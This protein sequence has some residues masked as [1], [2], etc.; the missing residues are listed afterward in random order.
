[1]EQPARRL[2]S[3]AG[4]KQKILVLCH[5]N[6]DPDAISSAFALKSLFS[7][8]LKRKAVIGFGGIVGRAENRELI[9]RLKI[10]MVQAQEIDFRRFSFICLVDS[11]PGI[12]NNSLPHGLLPNVVIDHHPLL[13]GTKKCEFYDVRPDYGSTATILTEY[14]RELGLRVE[15]RLATALFYGLKTDTNNLL[16]STNKADMDTF[17]FLFPRVAP[18]TLAAIEN[19]AIPHSY[20]RKFSEGLENSIQYKD[21]VISY[22]GTLSNPEIVAELAD[23]LLR[24]ENIRWTLC[25]GEFKEELVLSVRTNRRGYQA[26]KVAVRILRGIGQGGGHIKAAGGKVDLIGYSPEAKE[27]VKKEII[28]RFRRITG[29]ADEAG[30]LLI[31]GREPKTAPQPEPPV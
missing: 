18:K 6:P 3:L 14:L 8:A 5:N 10:E 26:G 27:R 11:Q 20:Y 16:R 22:A 15:R 23:F 29:V 31:A 19:P 30:R 7:Q 9:N 13:K 28:V 24:M 12:A 17:N 1:M 2:I 4:R 21:V 25:M